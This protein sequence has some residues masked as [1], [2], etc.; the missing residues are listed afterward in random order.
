[1]NHNVSVH[2]D[3]DAVK[4]GSWVCIKPR[5]RIAAGDRDGGTG[6]PL[7]QQVIPKVV[8]TKRGIGPLS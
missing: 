2:D 6:L 5:E 3:L 1:M 8:R 4:R 7:E